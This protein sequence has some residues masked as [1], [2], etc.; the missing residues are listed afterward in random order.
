M[1]ELFA[2]KIK[3]LYII[4]EVSQKSLQK[5]SQSTSIRIKIGLKNLKNKKT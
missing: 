2:K 1:Q 4:F 3:N 5:V